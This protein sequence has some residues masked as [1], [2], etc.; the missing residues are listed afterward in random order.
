[1]CDATIILIIYVMQ[2]LFTDLATVTAF[3]RMISIHHW[4]RCEEIDRHLISVDHFV[5]LFLSF[6]ISY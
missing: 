1:M 2:P 3:F 6:Y 5:L 4:H